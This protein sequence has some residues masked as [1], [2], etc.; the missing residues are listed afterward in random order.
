MSMPEFP[1]FP[2][3]HETHNADRPLGP[4]PGRTGRN[5][6]CQPCCFS[7]GCSLRSS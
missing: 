2:P 3:R 4:A 6:G 7:W 5:T 1:E